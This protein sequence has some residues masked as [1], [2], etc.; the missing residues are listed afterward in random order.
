MD[1]VHFWVNYI[2]PFVLN[3]VIGAPIWRLHLISAIIL[4]IVTCSKYICNCYHNIPYRRA[5]TRLAGLYA[6]SATYIV[7]VE[8]AKFPRC[9]PNK[10]S[11][12]LSAMNRRCSRSLELT[13]HILARCLDP[14][15][16]PR[17]LCAADVY[18]CH[19][20]QKLPVG[21]SEEDDSQGMT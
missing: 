3:R 10:T 8:E 4:H 17:G 5:S 14:Q 12:Y 18:T 6:G 2:T 15:K 9:S 11:I 7:V 21:R 16:A 19:L 20:P 13:S 1:L